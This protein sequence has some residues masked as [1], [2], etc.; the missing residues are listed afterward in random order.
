MIIYILPYKL[1]VKWG[2]AIYNVNKI[3]KH[4]FVR[5]L[6]KL[7]VS[8]GKMLRIDWCFRIDTICPKQLEKF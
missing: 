5:R 7:F 6:Q 3:V 1:Y 8:L 4:P 2:L